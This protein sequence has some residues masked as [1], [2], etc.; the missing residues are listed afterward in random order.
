MTAR[1][2]RLRESLAEPLLVTSPTNVRYLTGFESTNAAVLVEPGG[3]RLFADFRYAAA[4]R[5]VPDVEFEETARSIIADLAGRLSGRVAFEAEHLPYAD[6]ERL[7]SGGLDL[8]PTRRVVEALRAV[9]DEGELQAIAKAAAITNEVFER[10]ADE[11]FLGRTEADVAWNVERLFRELGADG[12]SFPV[13]VATGS[14]GAQPHAHPGDRK[15]ERGHAVV[16]DAGCLVD[17]YC[18]DCTRTFAAGPLSDELKEA[19]AV[20]LEAQTIGLAQVS[21]GRG[22]REIDAAAR[23]RI[24]EAGFGEAFGHG[25][26]HGVGLLVH[27]DPRLAQTSEDVLS[28]RNVVTVEPGIYLEGVGGIRIED[29]VVVGEN[30]PDVLTTF[31]KELVTVG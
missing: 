18:S 24:E 19:Y 26:G 9:K 15:I 7:A 29:L 21:P 25:L 12:L 5:E 27:E 4:A 1:I 10:V 17:G 31:P 3:V 8:V 14:N 16:L 13:A 20:C 6:W 2:A 23:N 11:P 30:G 28:A 22:G